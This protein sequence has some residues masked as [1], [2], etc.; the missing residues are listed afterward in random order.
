MRYIYR[1]ILHPNKRKNNIL[2]HGDRFKNNWTSLYC[3]SPLHRNL[4]KSDETEEQI[5]M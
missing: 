2:V 4:T 1:K 5:F 3:P